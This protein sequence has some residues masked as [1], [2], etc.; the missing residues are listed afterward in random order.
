MDKRLHGF[1]PLVHCDRT[2]DQ[3]PAAPR[4]VPADPVGSPPVAG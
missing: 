4:P 1:W 3:L 2:N